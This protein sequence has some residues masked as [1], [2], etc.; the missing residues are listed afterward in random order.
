MVFCFLRFTWK[1][2]KIFL[3]LM[4]WSCN[5]NRFWL[6]ISMCMTDTHTHQFIYSTKTLICSINL[7]CNKSIFVVT[8]I[9]RNTRS[10]LTLVSFLSQISTCFFLLSIFT[11]VGLFNKFYLLCNLLAKCSNQDWLFKDFTWRWQFLRRRSIAMKAFCF[12]KKMAAMM[13]FTVRKKVLPSSQMITFV[14]W[15]QK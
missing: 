14:N 15:K 9:R 1:L 10:K 11:I 7:G 6:S 2:A 4:V 3:C 12:H 8:Q 13:T 5:W